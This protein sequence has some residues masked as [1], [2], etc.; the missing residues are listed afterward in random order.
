MFP[1][2]IADAVAVARDEPL[3]ERDDA[4]FEL[5]DK[6]LLVRD[7]DHRRAELIDALE[8]AHDLQRTRGV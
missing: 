6:I 1:R 4:L 8:Q 2:I 5:V 3:I 7:D